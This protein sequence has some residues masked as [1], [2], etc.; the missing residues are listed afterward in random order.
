MV[1]VSRVVLETSGHTSMDDVKH[2]RAP[3]NTPS[4]GDRVKMRGREVFGI[5]RK[6]NN[7]N[8]AK[9]EWDNDSHGP[10]LCHLFELERMEKD[11]CE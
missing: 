1:L 3:P 2:P 11:K 4:V 9:V 8:W 5:L 7:I 6:I 10:V